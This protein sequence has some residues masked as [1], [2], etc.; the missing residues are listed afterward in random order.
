MRKEILRHSYHPLLYNQV[1]VLVGTLILI[2]A[3][4]DVVETKLIIIWVVFFISSIII[5]I[6]TYFFYRKNKNS[7]DDKIIK[8]CKNNFIYG[9]LY[10]GIVW[11]SASIF[12]FPSH[13]IIHQAYLVITIILI[14]SISTISLIPSIK[15]IYLI[16]IPA[17]TPLIIQL[18]ILNASLTNTFA[19]ILML[20]LTLLLRAGKKLYLI[21]KENIYYK[22]LSQEN[23]IISKDNENKY[24]IFYEKSK[25]AIFIIS[26]N[27]ISMANPAAVKLF[28][29]SSLQQMLET[30]PFNF[31]PEKQ[32]DGIKSIEKLKSIYTQISQ[33][34]K[35]RFNWVYRTLNG[36]EKPADISL[37]VIS[38]GNQ[39][40]IFCMV[41]DMTEAKKYEKDLILAQKNASQANQAKS[42]FLANMSHE[43]RTPMNGI[44]GS[45]NLL[46]QH[47]LN[48][49]QYLRALTINS[50]ASAML[51]I[52]NNILDFSKIEAGKIDL[53]HINFDIA[54]LI[55]EISSSTLNSALEKNLHFSY[56][57]PKNIHKI[58]I[59]DPG[60]IRQILDNLLNNAIKFT[61]E[62]QVLLS[63]RVLKETSQESTIEFSVKDTGIGLSQKQLNRLFQPFVQGDSSTT[64]KYGGT[65]LGLSICNQLS[66]QM[67][68][69]ITVNTTI[70][71]GSQFIFTLNLKKA[72]DIKNTS[73][74]SQGSVH[75]KKTF[76]AKVLV[77]DDMTV[78]LEVTMGMLEVFGIDVVLAE[79]G[80]EA[81][82]HLKSEKFDLVL[83]DCQMPIMD[84]Y[85]ATKAI[86][87]SE[88]KIL[89]SKVPIIAMT[90]NAMQGDRQICLDAGMDDYLAKPLG[91]DELKSILDKWLG[92][93]MEIKYSQTLSDST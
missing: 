45:T 82:E 5:R 46:L 70:S 19:I 76:N 13:S 43:I 48:Q 2:S 6:Y 90:A 10:V 34:G 42:E 73:L 80:K 50:S 32:P 58:Y 4:K 39:Q 18:L 1:G 60:R 41:R 61:D 12:L 65:G 8:K 57:I 30:N 55:Q 25:D 53:E 52:L 37:S 56:P 71:E 91:L 51:T 92:K 21:F 86:R 35:Y 87:L 63:C 72:K 49:D 22:H 14:I 75:E 68:G 33:T 89:N 16:V 3:I 81:I 88:P 74:H 84:G 36:H 31:A 78:N 40:A 47:E 28:E 26:D 59:G 93:K 85:Q 54:R 77:V 67:G 24:R 79:N 69:S 44:I 17:I 62:G 9:S 7:S 20:Y 83:M 23:E 11:G 27:K 64:R 29:C 66:E 15:S 38:F